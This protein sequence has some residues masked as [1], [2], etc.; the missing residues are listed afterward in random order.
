MDGACSNHS[1]QGC[2]AL[3]VMAHPLQNI[4]GEPVPWSEL[5]QDVLSVIGGLMSCPSQL[6]S[7][8]K[9]C[10]N[11]NQ[12]I[13][14]GVERLELDMNPCNQAWGAKV[15]Q[16]QRFTPNLSRC[17][18]HVGTAVPKMAFGAN[19]RQLATKLHNI[20]V[21]LLGLVGGVAAARMSTA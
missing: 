12:S 18:A 9:V 3:D 16:L 19:L 20:Q 5:P 13:P 10:K 7:A 17:K 14:S 1:M 4:T 6:N 2:Q 11:W 15:E 21:R 8:T